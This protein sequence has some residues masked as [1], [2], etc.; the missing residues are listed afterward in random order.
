M[1]K[2]IS[3]KTINTIK[4]EEL[5]LPNIVQQ[6]TICKHLH[7]NIAGS[8]IKFPAITQ[9]HVQNNFFYK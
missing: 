6:L 7:K 3:I 1:S 9:K 4:N 5:H 2:L 8:D